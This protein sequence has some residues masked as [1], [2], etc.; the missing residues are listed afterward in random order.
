MNFPES[1]DKLQSRKKKLQ[2]I[3]GKEFVSKKINWFKIGEGVWQGCILLSCLFNLH[4]VYIMWNAGLDESK[5]RIKIV[6]RNINNVRY[7]D[8]TTL[9]AKSEEELKSLL[10]RMKEESKKGGLKLSIQKN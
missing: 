10:K 2:I 7:A 1:E 6:R 5:T 9:L 8:D 3:Y 4:D